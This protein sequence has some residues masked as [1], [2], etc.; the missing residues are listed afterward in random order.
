MAWV[1]I[2]SSQT[3]AESPL[4]DTL[5]D[6]I[7]TNLDLLRASGGSLSL[8]AA[9]FG[10]DGTDG[11]YAPGVSANLEVGDGKEYSSITIA[12]GVTITITTATNGLARIGCQGDCVI[13]GAIVVNALGGTGGAGGTGTGD[14]GHPG[15]DATTTY[16]TRGGLFLF[17]GGGGGGAGGNYSENGGAGG[18]GENRSAIDGAGAPTNESS[19]DGDNGTAGYGAILYDRIPAAFIASGAGGGG[20]GEGGATDG[21]CGDGGAGGAGGGSLAMEIGGD[22]TFT[23]SITANGAAGSNGSTGNDAGGGGGGG[24]GAGCVQIIAGSITSQSGSITVNGGAG[25]TGG[26]D[27][28]DG[29]DGG[30]GGAGYSEIVDLGG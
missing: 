10:G 20:G 22:L 19:G 8:F 6:A 26:N 15:D 24:G 9:G 12:S 17:A 2:A 29:G 16:R 30:A 14:P 13:E 3:D 28:H 21:D 11:D 23:G 18:A 27:S 25:G 4:D 1:D 5:M 7:R